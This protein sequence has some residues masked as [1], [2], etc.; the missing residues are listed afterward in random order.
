MEEN[1]KEIEKTKNQTTGKTQNITLGASLAYRQF[2]IDINQ[3]SRIAVRSSL[4]A[5][6]GPEQ[7]PAISIG[8]SPHDILVVA[9]TP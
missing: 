6:L 3:V 8:G 5:L 9:T 4:I 1:P 7:S 2:C